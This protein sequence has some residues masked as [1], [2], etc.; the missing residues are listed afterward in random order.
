MEW[1]WYLLIAVVVIGGGYI[2]L[3]VL[4]KWMESRKRKETQYAE[5]D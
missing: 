4:G 5:E 1:Y 2:K 3:K